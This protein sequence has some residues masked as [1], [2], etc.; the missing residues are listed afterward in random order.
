MNPSFNSSDK[1]FPLPKL[2]YYLLCSAFHQKNQSRKLSG[3]L[4]FGNVTL[5]IKFIAQEAW[6]HLGMVCLRKAKMIVVVFCVC[7]FP[8]NPN[9]F[10][11]S[12]W[13]PHQHRTTEAKPNPTSCLDWYFFNSTVPSPI[14][15]A[16]W[17]PIRRFSV[18]VRRSH[19]PWSFSLYSCW[20][21]ATIYRGTKPE[22][23]QGWPHTHDCASSSMEYI[24]QVSS[25][26]SFL[27]ML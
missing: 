15:K 9:Y 3:L 10:P 17:C 4:E 25:K 12:N 8:K 20:R 26:R 18:W 27:S 5:S 6:G 24:L 16:S 1:V 7:F 11:N 13:I 14:T 19:I 21:S 23:L 22:H 2:L